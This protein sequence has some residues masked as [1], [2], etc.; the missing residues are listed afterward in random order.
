[1]AR[2]YRSA[3]VETDLIEIWTSIAG[4][5]PAAADRVLDRIEQACV[6]L[7]THPHAGNQRDDLAPGLRFYPVGNYLVFYV[8]HM[9][10]VSRL[11]GFFMVREIT[12]KNFVTRPASNHN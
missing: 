4:D 10:M 12:D 7:A 1:M 6:L 3:R 2:T 8:P 5:D 9:P 11:P